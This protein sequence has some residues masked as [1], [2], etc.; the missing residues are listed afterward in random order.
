[1]VLKVIIVEDEEP[2]IDLLKK[3]LSDV[4][5]LQI[6]VVKVIHSVA[7]L[8]QTIR[9]GV[10]TDLVFMD[11]HLRDGLSVE[12]FQQLHFPYPVIFVTAYDS[13]AIQAFNLSA[14]DYILKPI[15]PLML[16][17]AIRKFLNKEN[18]KEKK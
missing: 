7:E 15:D 13:Y 2:A 11:I 9:E 12:I 3:E 17:K 18:F 16:H 5:D 1:M 8:H 6:D 4:P 10:V 14:I